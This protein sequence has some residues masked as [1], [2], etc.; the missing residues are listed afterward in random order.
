MLPSAFLHISHN[1]GSREEEE[2][3]EFD[4]SSSLSLLE[5]ESEA[6]AHLKKFQEKTSPRSNSPYSS[7]TRV[8]TLARIVVD[9]PL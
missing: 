7:D 8:L 9:F 5:E 4:V 2:E 1:T 6:L 3:E